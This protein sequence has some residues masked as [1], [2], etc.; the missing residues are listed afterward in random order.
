MTEPAAISASVA[1]GVTG[2]APSA[3]PATQMATVGPTPPTSQLKV[4][5]APN[6]V[7]VSMQNCVSETRITPAGHWD[8]CSGIVQYASATSLIAASEPGGRCAIRL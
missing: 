4:E 7:H 3:T 5:W 8:R 6:A 2:E 1:A